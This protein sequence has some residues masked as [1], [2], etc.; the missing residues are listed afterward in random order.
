MDIINAETEQELKSTAY[1]ETGHAIFGYLLQLGLNWVTI[2]P[3]ESSLGSTRFRPS[4]WQKQGDLYFDEDYYWAKRDIVCT[5]AGVETESLITGL[6]NYDDAEA[7]YRMI[8]D[9]AMR[10]WGSAEA[11]ESQLQH[12]RLA[13]REII[14]QPEMRSVIDR[15]AATLLEKRKLNYAQVKQ[16]VEETLPAEFQ[17]KL[18]RQL[19]TCVEDMPKAASAHNP[20]S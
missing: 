10:V 3:S 12:K 18:R 2:S 20:A 13:V 19:R 8:G 7:D 17:P 5:L 1:H 4:P 14:A 6:P 16:I 9:L 15:L 11:I